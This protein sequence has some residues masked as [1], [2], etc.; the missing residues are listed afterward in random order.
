[1][2]RGATSLARSMGIAKPMPMLPEQ[3]LRVAIWVLMPMMLAASTGGPPEFPRVM[4]AS[5][6]MAVRLGPS[7]KRTGRSGW[8]APAFS[9]SSK[10]LLAYGVVEK[11]GAAR[12]TSDHQVA[13]L[14]TRSALRVRG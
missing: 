3:R 8:A 9:T 11:V 10:V 4:E 1:M 13:S 14:M 6:W 7:S 5:D 12:M 2:R